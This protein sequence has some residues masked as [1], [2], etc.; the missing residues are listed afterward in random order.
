MQTEFSEDQEAFREFG[1][2][3]GSFQALKHRCADRLLEVECA[4]AAVHHAAFCLAAEEGEPHVAS[5]AKAMAAEAYMLAAKEA[6]QMRG[7]IGFTSEEDT[8]L[9]YKRAESSEVLMGTPAIHR[10]RMMQTIEQAS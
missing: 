5:M 4:K 9:W 8:H 10:E 2:P 6:I 1:R 7:G 3:I